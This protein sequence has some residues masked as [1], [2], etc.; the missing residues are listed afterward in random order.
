VKLSWDIWIIILS[1]FQAITIPLSISF[2][3]DYFNT[4]EMKTLNSLIDLVFTFDII[5]RFRTTYIDSISGEEVMD[6]M[7]IA[8]RYAKSVTF[9]IDVLSTV[10]LDDFS[11]GEN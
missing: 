5:L 4:P 2:E 9:V 3:P 11:G 8:K 1:V 10:P 7:L 6:S